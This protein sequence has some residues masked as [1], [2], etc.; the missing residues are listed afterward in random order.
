[1]LMGRV[2]GGGVSFRA[3]DVSGAARLR[4][5]WERHYRHSDAVIFVVDSADHLRLGK[6]LLQRFI[7]RVVY[8]CKE[9]CYVSGGAV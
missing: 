8:D 6:L 5:L 2:S 4:A 9:V 3:W 1:M 7:R